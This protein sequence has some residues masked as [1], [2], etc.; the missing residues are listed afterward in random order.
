MYFSSDLADGSESHTISCNHRNDKAALF[1]P[2]EA[3]EKRSGNHDAVLL[4]IA[5]VEVLVC[6]VTSNR[7]P[8]GK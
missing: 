1:S 3:I 4:R 8:L 2:L 6:L 5:T 7:R